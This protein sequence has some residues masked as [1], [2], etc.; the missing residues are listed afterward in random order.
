MNALISKLIGRL[1]Q[2]LA[3]MLCAF[4]MV[5]TVAII[6]AP[7]ASA[8]STHCAWVSPVRI[9]GRTIPLGSYCFSVNGSGLNINNTLSSYEAGWVE[10][11]SERVDAIDTSG[12]T[13]ASWWT[14]RGNGT[15]YGTHAWTSGIHGSAR[16][17]SLCGHLFSNGIQIAAVCNGIHT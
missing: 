9:F 13:Y 4:G 7:A 8:S 12:N 5:G 2:R 16:P 10:N 6:S 11:L 15:L 17:G 3:V 14:Y 1:P